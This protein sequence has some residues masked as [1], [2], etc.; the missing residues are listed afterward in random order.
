M[1][2]R[3]L[4]LF[5][6]LLA[7]PA[8]AAPKVVVTLK[9]VHSLV[10]GV[11]AGVGQPRLL[12]AANGDAHSHALRPSE[13]RAL[14]A[15]DLVIWV[16]PELEGYLAK[17]LSN[18]VIKARVI[19]LSRAPDLT[20]MAA[21]AGGVWKGKAGN[22]GSGGGGGGGDIDPHLWLDTRN[23][24]AIVGQAVA[25]LS[26]LDPEHTTA[27]RRNGNDMLVRLGALEMQIHRLLAPVR[28]LPYVVLHDAYQYFEARFRTLGIG[29]IA[30]A[31]D[32]K[33]G[34]RRLSAIRQRLR[35]GKT[36]CLFQDGDFNSNI[37]QALIQGLDMRV[38]VLDPIGRTVPPGPDAY[39]VTLRQLAG[40]LENCLSYAI[41]P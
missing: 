11:M 41:G 40:N 12:L 34:A 13:A 10:A 20:L 37:V 14:A 39:Y 30:I 6:A 4:F 3:W 26:R 38:A 33:P 32:R 29:A 35:Q 22:G 36:R 25:A 7:A 19:T 28:G 2:S 23:A 15:A 1:I 27:Y 9:P 18:M 16:G 5:L 17:A 21:R 8:F 24:K 31:P